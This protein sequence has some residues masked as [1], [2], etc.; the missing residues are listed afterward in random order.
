MSGNLAI[1]AVSAVMKYLLQNPLPADSI[2]A[3]VPDLAVTV[4]PPHQVDD[5]TP[6]LNIFFYRA[7]PNP[8]WAQNNLPSRNSQG[9]RTSN[10]KLKI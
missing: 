4:I 8:G 10:P 5:D 1:A 3:V 9:A 6:H 2:A 7:L